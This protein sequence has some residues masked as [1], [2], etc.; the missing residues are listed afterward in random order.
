MF[1]GRGREVYSTAIDM[2]NIRWMEADSW[3]G[4]RRIGGNNLMLDVGSFP[5]ESSGQPV[6][7]LEGWWDG[8]RVLNDDDDDDDG[9]C[10]AAQQ[11]PSGETF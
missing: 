9:L 10:L 5:L 11:K 3:K 2:M 1:V 7:D 6:D 8:F 4:G